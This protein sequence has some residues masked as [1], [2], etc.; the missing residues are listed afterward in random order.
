MSE[1]QGARLACALDAA[2]KCLAA[3]LAVSL[4]VAGW[5]DV[6]QAYDV[7][8]YH[9]PFA[10]RIAG[11][12]D[13]GTYAFSAENAVRYQGFPLLAEALQGLVWRATGHVE[14]TSFV[15]LASLFA[16]PL[17]LRRLFGAPLHL[18][19][20]ALLAIPLVHVHATSSYVDLPGNACATMLL[21]C[22]YRL[23]TSEAGRA[24]SLRFLVGCAVLAAAAANTRFQVLPIVA[25][26]SAVVAFCSL[27]DLRSWRRLDRPARFGL[28]KRAIVIAIAAPIVLA[29]PIKNGIRHGNPVWPVEL[30]V[31][32]RTL[33]YAEEAYEQS[34]VHLVDAPRPVRFVRSVLEIDNL[35]V[36]TGRRW[37]IDQWAPS[38]HPSCR[39]G[40]YFGAYVAVNLLAL[41]WAAWRRRTRETA[42]AAVLFGV[43][44]I[45]ASVV[46][47][48]HELRYYMH[49]MLL[50]VSLNVILWAQKAPA[51]AGVVATAALAVVVWTTKAGYLYPSGS[52]FEQFLAKR[53]D[54]AVV[55][56]AAPGERL[57]IAR[58]PFTFLYAPVFHGRDDYTVQEATSDAD[59]KGA[60]RVP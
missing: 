25:I 13:E 31:L 44:T 6:S 41:G 45:V 3:A 26:A 22:V 10:A 49:W 9:V 47:Q 52:T 12:V 34:P 11:I 16:I 27:R 39:M 46:P 19:L 54:R 36:S 55:E 2:L 53:V 37:S 50:L 15:S 35:P 1:E 24:R 21:L 60:R 33:P 29:T 5:H 32:G 30:H 57:C 59:C 7:W 4:V 20:L 17:L 51:A 8:Y 56:S 38:D 58:E 28:V 40:G 48:S 23:T 18:S 43:V 42:G 14:A